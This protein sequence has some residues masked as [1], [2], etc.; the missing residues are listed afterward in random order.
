MD[1]KLLL[2]VLVELKMKRKRSDHFKLKL[3]CLIQI[4][5]C[6]QILGL[7]MLAMSSVSVDQMKKVELP[8]IVETTS[9]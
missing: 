1:S 2:K 5:C 7:L 9:T 8:Q 4:L 6:R 3:R